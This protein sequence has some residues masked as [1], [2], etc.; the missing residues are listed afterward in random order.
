MQGVAMSIR[1]KPGRPTIA[2]VFAAL[3][4]AACSGTK[5]IDTSSPDQVIAGV[6]VGDQVVITSKAG[7]HYRFI[8]SKMTNKALY[9]ADGTK[10]TYAEMDKVE[11][12]KPK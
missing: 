4:L 7:K 9:A 2:L 6:N 3:L 12:S 5:R 11:A 10:V 8:V 1:S